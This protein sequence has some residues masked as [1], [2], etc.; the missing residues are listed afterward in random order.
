MEKEASALNELI[1]KYK[2]EMENCEKR[3]EEL[4]RKMNV[5]YEAMKLLEQESAI[6]PSESSPQKTFAPVSLSEKYKGV[7]MTKAIMDIL[8]NTPHWLDGHRIADELL[9]NGFTSA[10]SNIQRDVYIALYRMEK[11]KK[12]FSKT[13]DGRKH[14]S[15]DKQN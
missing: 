6:K 14:Y 15:A 9:K 13:K 12:I 10:S 8:V 7:S 2:T 4:K 1:K 3:L 11:E 5:A